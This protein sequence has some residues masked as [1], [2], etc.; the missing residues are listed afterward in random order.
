MTRDANLP[1]H[2]RSEYRADETL[3]RLRRERRAHCTKIGRT[4]M[5]KHSAALAL[6]VACAMPF[7]AYAVPP[8][9]QAEKS[10]TA[11]LAPIAAHWVLVQTEPSG[12]TIYDR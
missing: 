12:M 6:L 8:I 5:K 3:R 9:L 1:E 11:T 10:D 4:A 7:A 2:C